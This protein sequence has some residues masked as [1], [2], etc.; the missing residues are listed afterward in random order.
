MKTSLSRRRSRF[1]RPLSWLVVAGLA[2]AA[3]IGPGVGGAAAGGPGSDDNL[4]NS[5]DHSANGLTLVMGTG[6]MSC[7]DNSVNS[8]SGSFTYS[9]GTGTIT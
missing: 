6:I 5:G 8:L 3:I 7:T 4:P 9:G 2:G 1:A